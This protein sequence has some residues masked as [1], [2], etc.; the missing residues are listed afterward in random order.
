MYEGNPGEINFGSG[1]REGFEV[2]GVNCISN[3]INN[4]S[5]LW[6][7]V[8]LIRFWTFWK[9]TNAIHFRIFFKFAH[10]PTL[11]RR[12]FW[13][14]SCFGPPHKLKKFQVS[15]ISNSEFRSVILVFVFYFFW[16]TILASNFLL[17]YSDSCTWLIADDIT[18]GPSMF[19]VV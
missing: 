7:T 2:S 18:G 11:P 19:T 3:V 17:V 6:K 9:T 4:K 14:S 15:F 10:Q 16:L 13:W 5:G 12:R 8:R 1:Q